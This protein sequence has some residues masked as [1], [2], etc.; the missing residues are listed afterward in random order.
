MSKPDERVKKAER[1]YSS[2][3]KMDRQVRI[4][5]EAGSDVSQPHRFWKKHALNCGNPKC[6]MCMNPR[7][8]FG[9][10]TIQERRFDQYNGEE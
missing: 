8:S 10:R 1:I 9:E 4:A 6:V 5:K 7:R 3:V 2:R